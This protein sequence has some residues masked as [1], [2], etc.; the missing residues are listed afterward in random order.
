MQ[1]E[2]LTPGTEVQKM[3][4]ELEKSKYALREHGKENARL[5]QE[6]EKARK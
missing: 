6:L 1:E 3:Q 4:R 2:A 5:E